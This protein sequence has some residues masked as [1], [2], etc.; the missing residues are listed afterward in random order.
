MNKQP[1]VCTQ[2]IL[3]FKRRV[4]G[5]LLTFELWCTKDV[6]GKKADEWGL[7]VPMDEKVFRQV[8]HKGAKDTVERF[9][10]KALSV[11]SN[12]PSI[13]KKMEWTPFTQD[14]LNFMD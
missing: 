9:R 13:E 2:G 7:S 4:E 3:Y 10:R 1:I 11:L 14:E 6:S 12:N 8:E 5:I